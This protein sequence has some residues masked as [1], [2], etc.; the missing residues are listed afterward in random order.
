MTIYTSTDD[1]GFEFQAA[2]PVERRRRVVSDS[3]VDRR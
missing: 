3:G 1:T 2:V